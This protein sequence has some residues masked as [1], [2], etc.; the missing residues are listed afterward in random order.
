MTLCQLA[1][2][3]KNRSLNFQ[4]FTVIEIIII[5]A[6]MCLVSNEERWISSSKNKLAF[7]TTKITN[8]LRD[9]ECEHHATVKLR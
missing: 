8:L 1:S 7:Y 5:K 2:I 4:G 6:S 9:A 3:L